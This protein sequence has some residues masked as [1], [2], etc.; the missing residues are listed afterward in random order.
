MPFKGD[1]PARTGVGNSSENCQFKTEVHKRHFFLPRK[2]VSNGAI[3]TSK[4][5]FKRWDEALTTLLSLLTLGNG[6]KNGLR[7]W[8]MWPVLVG[9]CCAGLILVKYI[10]IFMFS[11]AYWA[12]NIRF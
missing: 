10:Q 4:N 6:G 7:H 9:F 11:L 3:K 5:T 2:A 1:V 12:M 8:Y